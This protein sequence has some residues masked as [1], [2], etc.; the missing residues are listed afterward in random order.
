MSLPSSRSPLRGP[1]E[2]AEDE[3]GPELART[4]ARLRELLGVPFVPTVFRVLGPYEP[5]LTA[6][7]DALAGV[8]SGPASAEFAAAAR[9]RAAAATAEWRAGALCPGDRAADIGAMIERYNT[10]NPRNLLF[11]TALLPDSP[12]EA[13]VMAA[14]ATPPPPHD[15][16]ESILEDIR[17]VHGDYVLPGLWRE[18]AAHPHVLA[19]AWRAVR[20]LAGS[21]AFLEARAALTE[22]ARAATADVRVSDPAAH[23]LRGDEL[24]AVERVLAWFSDGIAAM[25]VEIE[26]LRRLVATDQ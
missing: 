1:G 21:P 20:P 4:Y 23:G 22:Q 15:D 6:A 7:T 9:R 5:Y 18:L 19:P 25:I 16:V 11:A 3:A 26:Y 24:Q 10:A 17:I 8:L 13:G 14:A 2:V 12:R